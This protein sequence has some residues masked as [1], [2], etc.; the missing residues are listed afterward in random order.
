MTEAHPS[1]IGTV[2]LFRES[3]LLLRGHARLFVLLMG[4]PILAQ[5]LAVIV[6]AILIL[7]LRP[8]ESLRDAWLAMDEWV[9]VVIDSRGVPRD[10]CC[11]LP[12]IGCVGLR[13][14]RNPQRP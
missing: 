14:R 4:V 9:K 6:M 12:R 7:P 11:R 13:R 3:W 5:L 8:G 10:P 1:G 2:E